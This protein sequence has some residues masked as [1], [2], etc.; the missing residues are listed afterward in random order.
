MPV[1]QLPKLIECS[2]LLRSYPKNLERD[3][4]SKSRGKTKL[5]DVETHTKTSKHEKTDSAGLAI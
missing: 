4:L 3:E 1:G 2:L 5:S